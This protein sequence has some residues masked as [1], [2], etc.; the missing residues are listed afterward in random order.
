MM[1]AMKIFFLVLSIGLLALPLMAAGTEAA[2]A[3]LEKQWVDAVLKSDTATLAKLVSDDLTYT[4]SNTKT[5]TKQQFIDAI[6]APAGTPASIK[7]ENVKTRVYG[8]TAVVTHV[9]YFQP[10][11][12]AVNHLYITHVW[13]K[14]KGGW[15]MV[16]RQATRFPAQ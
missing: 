14:G 4:H 7:F 2:I 13:A 15:Q 6:T 5:E 8:N 10:K 3:E 12:G 9:A 11:T 1:L 16:S